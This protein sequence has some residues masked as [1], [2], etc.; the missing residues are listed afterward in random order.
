MPEDLRRSLLELHRAI[1]AVE[2]EDFER[3]NGTVSAGE[4]LRVRVED[5]VWEWLRPL[6]TLIVQ[7]DE[8]EEG[9]NDSWLAEAR[10]LLKPDSAGGPFQQRYAWLIERSPDVLYA[11]GVLMHALKEAKP[12]ER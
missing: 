7:L 4:F 9:A 3:R 6:S 11:H 10:R 8:L 2:R 5:P 12:R 1:V